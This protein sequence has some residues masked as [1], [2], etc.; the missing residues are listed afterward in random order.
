MNLL[1]IFSKMGLNDWIAIWGALLS[2]VLA[3][4]KI[5]EWWRDRIQLDISFTCTTSEYEGN[6][7]VIRNL[8][9]MPIIIT[10]WEI[11]LAKNLWDKS[12]NEP[13]ES[14]DFDAGDQVVAAHASVHWNYSEARFFSTSE[15]VL[16]GRSIFLKLYIAGRKSVVRK[17]YP[18]T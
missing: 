15:K 5:A 6:S 11:F 14:A 10:Y 12:D 1:G 7:I 3:A 2:T 8:Y 18:F 13:I 4:I 16:K 9:S 17:L